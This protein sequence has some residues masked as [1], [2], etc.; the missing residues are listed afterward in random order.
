M[1]HPLMQQIVDAARLSGMT[2]EQVDA[3]A[4]YGSGGLSRWATNK[5]APSV[6][7]FVDYANTVGL[8]VELVPDHGKPIFIPA[9]LPLRRRRG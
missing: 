4:G 2:F 8:S 3:K 6:Y 1:T 5:G 9:F 7:A